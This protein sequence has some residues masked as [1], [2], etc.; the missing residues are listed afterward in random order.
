MKLKLI[1][2]VFICILTF[3]LIERINVEEQGG[4]LP[5]AETDIPDIGY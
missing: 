4:I 3:N 5:M 1:G 2:V